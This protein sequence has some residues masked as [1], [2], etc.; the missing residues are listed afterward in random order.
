MTHVRFNQ[1]DCM[2]ARTE[3]PASTNRMNWL[4]NDFSSN[5]SLK[6]APLANIVETADDYRLELIVPGFS[7]SD[8]RIQLEDRVL[9]IS[10]EGPAVQEN[11]EEAYIR[12]EFSRGSFSRSFR[13]SDRLDSG[14]ISAKYENGILMVTIPKVEEAKAKPAREIGIE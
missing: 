3:F 4:W 8:F 2:P 5:S 10:A 14:N 13:L 1:R 11:G 12:R 9:V 6:P 7:K